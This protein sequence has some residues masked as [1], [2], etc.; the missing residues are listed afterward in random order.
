MTTRRLFLRALAGLPLAASGA[1][2]LLASLMPVVRPP[3]SASENTDLLLQPAQRDR[4]AQ[5]QN[6]ELDSRLRGTI[7]IYLWDI[8]DEG[9]DTVFRRL[10][11]HRLT[12]I[13]LAT[14]YHA[15]KFLAPHNPKR[16]VV[17]LEDGTVYFRPNPG[18]YGKIKPRVN[19]LVDK[20]HDLKKVQ[21][22]AERFGLETRSW[23]VC[24]HNTPLGRTY[25]S[26]VTRTAFG[27]PL[28]H[29][30]CPSNDD[31]RTYLRAL[32][33]DIA[34]QG[35]SA[36]ELEALQF[37]GYTHGEHHEREGILLGAI[38]RFLLGL[39]FCDSCA[40]RAQLTGLNLKPIREFVRNTLEECFVDPE[41]VAGRYPA[42]EALPSGLFQPFMDWRTNVVASL[43][44][45]VTEAAGTVT[46]RPM[47]SPD[48]VVR[49]MVGMNPERVAAITGGVLMLGYVRDGAA[50]RAPL[51]QLQAMIPG[52]DI[53]V[54]IQVGML[55]SGAKT[56]FLDRVKTARE[57]GIT[58]FNFY[59]YGFV[60]LK[61]LAWIAESLGPADG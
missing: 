60:P 16:K 56:E 25:P 4:F 38:P 57:M 2:T 31:V 53:T 45:E 27:D 1:S 47:V 24:C 7:W 10:K 35:V 46:V 49:T 51:S 15:G 21:Q 34:G 3:G 18:L 14:A 12:G 17:F 54:G 37:Q 11:E 29:N 58:S 61:N 9:Y 41:A 43:V 6:P 42:L 26:I 23:V 33:R 40:K 48:P 55:E 59:N 8:V 36:I 28:Y 50:L 19:S 5:D 22:Q 44:Q 32:V 30:L 39:C 20:G 13:S 52:R